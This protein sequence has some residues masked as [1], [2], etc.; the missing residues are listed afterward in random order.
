MRY[1][2]QSLI[3]PQEIG[4][5]RFCRNHKL[6][7]QKIG[8]PAATDP[9]V[10][11]AAEVELAVRYCLATHFGSLSP[12]RVLSYERRNA[13][14]YQRCYRELD[15]VVGDRCHPQFFVEIKSFTQR[16]RGIKAGLPQLQRSL[17]IAQERWRSLQGILIE[18]AWM[19]E[20]SEQESTP[21]LATDLFED[22]A[23]CQKDESDE[24]IT[25]IYWSGQQ[26]AAGL[27]ELGMP[28]NPDILGW[29]NATWSSQNLAG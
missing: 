17:V 19:T 15:A 13:L 27:A 9:T 1:R 3:D 11:L 29:A 12:H 8:T 2:Q 22:L 10:V 14:G 20:L 6:L 25:P 26:L 24:R 21:L 16:G 28:L 4:Y 23:S 18:V 5:R 7:N